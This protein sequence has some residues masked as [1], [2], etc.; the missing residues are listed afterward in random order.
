MNVVPLKTKN[1]VI[2]KF[3]NG[4]KLEDISFEERISLS[5]VEEVIE[6]WKKG[7]I[8]IDPGNDIAQE[9][10]ELA[11]L[12]RDKEITV[13]D[14]IEGYHYY[15]IFKEK[16]KEGILGIVNEIYSLD[17]EKRQLFMKTVEKMMNLSKY[18]NIDYVEIPKAIEDMVEK[19]RE[20]NRELKSK[21]IQTLEVVERLATLKK[22]VDRM[23]E[24][25]KNLSRE[26][27]FSKYLKQEL[28]RGIEDENAIK[29]TIEG[30]KHADFSAMRMEE[31]AT[32]IALIKKREL[33]VDQFLKISR[34]FEELMQLGLT[35]PMMEKLLDNV[36]EYGMDIDEYLNERAVYARDKSAYSRS[37]KELVDAHKKAEKQIREL[38]EEIAVKKLK[39]GRL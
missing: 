25:K 33:S 35:V 3:I 23:E 19:G 17:N 14:I 15:N 30:I 26:I 31:T 18:R 4:R 20:L 5:S 24:E 11:L 13:Q 6:E 16:E 9:M 32:Q 7:Y 36:K 34:Y 1:R 38:N 29:N 28:P 37:L 10:K 2:V 27:A 12:L 22:D 8:N 39:V 21:E